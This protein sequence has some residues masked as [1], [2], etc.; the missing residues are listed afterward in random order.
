M[1][2]NRI[3]TALALSA[4][5]LAIAAPTAPALTTDAQ[6]DAVPG[7]RAQLNDRARAEAART[8]DTT[9]RG[10]TPAQIDRVPGLRAQLDAR[11]AAEAA[12]ASEGDAFDWND[13]GI[14]ALG[15]V[16]LIALGAGAGFM[17][18]RLRRRDVALPA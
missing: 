11:A 8:F 1:T 3:R 5:A 13:A 7:L 6:I 18:T 16:A 14:G 10:T 12:A 4:A 9:P 17:A 15:G 2:T